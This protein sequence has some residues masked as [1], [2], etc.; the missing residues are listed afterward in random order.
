MNYAMIDPIISKWAAKQCL[1]LYTQYQGEEV[2]SVDVVSRC[3]R[4]YQIWIDPPRG[5]EVSIH[6]WDYKKH[7]RD[8]SGPIEQLSQSLEEAIQTVKSWMD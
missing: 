5:R 7:R 1:T 4:K 2:R 6:A 8:W 3:G